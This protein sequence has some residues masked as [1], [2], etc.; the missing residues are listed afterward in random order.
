[1]Q[2]LPRHSNRELCSGAYLKKLRMA[3][4]LL[5][6]EFLCPDLLMELHMDR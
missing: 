2:E 6:D 4:D 5:S 3:R 1:M